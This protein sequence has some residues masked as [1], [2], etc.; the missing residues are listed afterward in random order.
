MYPS[1][2]SRLQH[3]FVGALAHAEAAARHAVHAALLP[4]APLAVRRAALRA[5]AEL[6]LSRRLQPSAEL[7]Q[8]GARLLLTPHRSQRI[9]F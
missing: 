4:A 6:V 2:C 7:P 9:S 8:L 1:S 5:L 3:A